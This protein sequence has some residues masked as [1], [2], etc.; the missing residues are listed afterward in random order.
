MSPTWCKSLA[1]LDPMDLPSLGSFPV[2]AA[3]APA[4]EPC[5]SEAW[6][7]PGTLTSVTW[8]LRRHLLKQLNSV[9]LFVKCD[10]ATRV[11][12][13]QACARD[14]GRVVGRGGHVALRR[15]HISVF[16]GSRESHY[17]KR[18]RQF[19]AFAGWLVCRCGIVAVLKDEAIEKVSHTRIR[20][21]DVHG[22]RP[23]NGECG[24]KDACWPL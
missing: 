1:L 14:V 7:L 13:P 8:A 19:K 6:R 9:N 5:R 20:P 16:D 23:S 11:I 12:W 2:R 10:V 4:P 15:Y 24:C 3:P 18:F 21:E 17:E 22:F